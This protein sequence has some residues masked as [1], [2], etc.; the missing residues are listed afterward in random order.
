M[1]Y[2]C[3]D[4]AFVGDFVEYSDSWSRIQVRET[5][6]SLPELAE[7][8]V[9]DEAEDALLKHLR[10]K[11]VA[12]H[13]TCVDAPPI[14]S[15]A[16]LTPR[17]TEQLDARLYQW[18]AQS[19]VHHLNSLTQLGNALGRKL[20]ATSDMSLNGATTTATATAHRRSRKR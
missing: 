14:I 10:P 9:G 20:F 7:A 17:R 6:A 2:D 4:P 3:D 18:F 19:W 16:D 15:P 13:L 8:N 5:W 12:V 1:R 11:I